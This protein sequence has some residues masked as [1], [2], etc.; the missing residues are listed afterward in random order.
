[1]YVSVWVYLSMCIC[2]CVYVSVCLYISCIYL[3]M[4]PYVSLCIY[5]C[6]S[7]CLCTYFYMHLCVSLCISLCVISFSGP[8]D[9]LHHL[10]H[11]LEVIILG[12]FLRTM[13]VRTRKAMPMSFPRRSGMTWPTTLA[14][15]VDA[16][17]M[18]LAVP[19]PSCHS[20]PEGPSIVF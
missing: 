18:F 10:H 12:S 11:L 8:L 19:W 6:L 5:V 9:L 14:A 3:C 4:Y 2:V 20:F 15:P 7:V 1:M 16:G 13:G 17:M